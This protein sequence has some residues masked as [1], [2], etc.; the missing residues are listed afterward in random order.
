MCTNATDAAREIAA[1]AK[2]VKSL[3]AVIA[4]CT[5]DLDPALFSQVLHAELPDVAIVGATTCQQAATDQGAGFSAGALLLGGDGLHAGAAL[6]AHDGDA[7]ALGARLAREALA[8]GRMTAKAARFVVVHPTPGIEGAFLQGVTDVLGPKVPV[9]GGSAAD[10]DISGRWQTFGAGRAATSGACVLVCDWRWKTAVTYQSG[11]VATSSRGIVTRADGR[12]IF[13]IDGKPAADVYMGWIDDVLPVDE[14]I[15]ARTSF[16]P[17]GVVR[18]S[19]AGLDV[20]VLVHPERVL[21]DKSIV[22][23]AEVSDGET[24]V[25]MESNKGLLVRRGAA[26]VRFAVT[27]AGLLAD[28][29]VAQLIMYCAGCSLA[30]GDEVPQMVAGVH[31][32]IAAPFVMPF[33]LGEQGSFTRGGAHHGNLMCSA[34]VLTNVP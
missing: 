20:H 15:L 7:R 5:I 12:R 21:A 14:V 8:D 24:L 26:V 11:Y 3:R 13:T 28:D 23:F 1:A 17:L 16:K 34:I 33:T 25:M 29:V 32:E 2:R 18:G 27:N 4:Y 19:A 6:G 10:N 22:T 31:S 9:I 30:I